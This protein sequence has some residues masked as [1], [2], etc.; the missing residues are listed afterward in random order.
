MTWLARNVSTIGT[1]GMDREV[2]AA[3]ELAQLI[4]EARDGSGVP[5]GA[6]FEA[7]GVEPLSISEQAAHSISVEAMASV[8][9]LTGDTKQIIRS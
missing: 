8:A 7:D 4:D 5:V 1:S 2:L 6:G 9:N 3:Q